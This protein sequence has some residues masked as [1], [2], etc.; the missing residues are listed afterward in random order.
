MLKT[1]LKAKYVIIMRYPVTL[2]W[3]WFDIRPAATIE[4]IPIGNVRTGA[5][6]AVMTEA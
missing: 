2:R 4:G 1:L 3:H 5:G 6:Q